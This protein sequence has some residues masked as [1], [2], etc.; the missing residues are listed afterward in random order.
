MVRRWRDGLLT[1]SMWAVIIKLVQDILRN[2]GPTH[3]RVIR[4]NICN[5]RWTR[6]ALHEHRGHQGKPVCCAR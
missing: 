1:I 6:E 5:G 4:C 3:S 2:T